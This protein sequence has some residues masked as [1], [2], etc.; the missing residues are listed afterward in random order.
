[1]QAKF[2]TF[3]GGEGVGKTTQIKKLAKALQ[4]QFGIAVETTREPGGTPGAEYMRHILL[5]KGAAEPLGTDLEAI[6]FAAARAD[7]VASRI[8]P[9]LESDIWVLCDRFYD[10]SRVYQGL[11]GNVDPAMMKALE[12]VAI[13]RTRPDLTLILDLPAAIGLKRVTKRSEDGP[14]ID[15][16]E[17]ETEETHEKMR[18]GFLDIAKAEPERCLIINAEPDAE[19]IAADILEKVIAHFDLKA[20]EQAGEAPDGQGTDE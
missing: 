11:A 9:C 20:T 5:T 17:K 1:M 19:T 7:H 3:E 2:I 14:D 15:R 6:L 10:S 4:T 16:Y 8:K 13:D 18:Q 12:R